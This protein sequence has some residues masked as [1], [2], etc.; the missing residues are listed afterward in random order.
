MRQ[1][2]IQRGYF[3]KLFPEKNLHGKTNKRNSVCR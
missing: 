1:F 3:G 2:D